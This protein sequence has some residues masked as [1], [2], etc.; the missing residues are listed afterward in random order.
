MRGVVYLVGA[1]P[2]DP[3]LITQRGA[4]LLARADVVVYDGLASP[5]LLRLARDGCERIYAGKK[6]SP[7]GEPLSQADIDRVLIDRALAG[8][9]VVRLKGGDPFLFGR[10]AEECE[11]LAAAGV[12]FE[13]VPGVS[14][15]TA[16]P[17]YAG[18]PLTAR[19]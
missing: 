9:R 17:A 16:V 10:G 6:R 5:V 18:I 13:V 19:G 12:A 11:A 14:S 3:G 7:A 1:G 4:D 8:K 15:A 2:G